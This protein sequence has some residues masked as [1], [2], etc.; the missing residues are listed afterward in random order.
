MTRPTIP[1][2]TVESLSATMTTQMTTQLTEQRETNAKVQASMEQ[3]EQ[4]FNS[5]L[6]SKIEELFQRLAKQ[7]AIVEEMTEDQFPISQH[8]DQH[9]YHSNM[10]HGRSSR[11]EEVERFRFPL[12]DNRESMTKRV[13]L[14]I[15][16]GD[17][18]YGWIALAER[19]FRIGRYSE[20]MKLE[21]ISVSLGGDVLSWFNSEVLRRP[22]QD[23][24][25]FKERL[26]AR[27]SK[28][29]LRDPSQPFFNVQ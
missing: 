9:V 20:E 22:Y 18:A 23:W 1:S 5:R 25:D 13:E 11:E 8:R 17:D 16:S 19:F 2:T 6:D 15:F 28:V 10:E 27:F 3:M 21:L 24:R 14:P 26:I 7:K 4:Q 29:K 12:M